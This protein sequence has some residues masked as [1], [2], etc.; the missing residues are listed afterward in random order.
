MFESW[1]EPRRRWFLVVFVATTWVG[2][3]NALAMLGDRFTTGGIGS[4]ALH[5][6]K[7][8]AFAGLATLLF[9]VVRL[10]MSDFVAAMTF[11][12]AISAALVEFGIRDHAAA[13]TWAAGCEMDSGAAC[14][15]LADYYARG[16]SPVHGWLD[17]V[18]LYVRACELGGATARACE[19][20]SPFAAKGTAVRDRAV[21]EAACARGAVSACRAAAQ[22]TRARGEVLAAY[23][24]DQRACALRDEAACMDLLNSGYSELRAE[25]CDALEVQCRVSSS[26]ACSVALRRCERVRSPHAGTR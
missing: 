16:E 18:P 23:R 14:E 26:H 17:A 1:S 11:G 20:A 19:V 12:V 7:I 25:A 8:L 13:A 24:F 6:G 9:G 22:A 4:D 10:R 2:F 3:V 21:D 15:K 5:F